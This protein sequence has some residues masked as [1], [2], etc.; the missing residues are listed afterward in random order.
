M[1]EW[2]ETREGQQHRYAIEAERE[3]SC[4][5]IFSRKNLNTQPQKKSIIIHSLNNIISMFLSFV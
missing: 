5:L 1:Y 2:R 3:T 4:V